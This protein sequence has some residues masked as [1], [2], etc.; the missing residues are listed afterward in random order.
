MTLGV[1]LIGQHPILFLISKATYA[2]AS[3]FKR[4]YENYSQGYYNK[5]VSIAESEIQNCVASS[6][7]S[8]IQAASYFKLGDF[9][10][11]HDILAEL[12]KIYDSEPDYLSLYAAASRRLGHL[13][14]SS[15]LFKLALSIEPNSLPIKNNYANLLIDLGQFEEAKQLLDEV[16]TAVPSYEDA[17]KNKNRLQFLESNQH[18]PLVTDNNEQSAGLVDLGDPLLLAFAD[19]EVKRSDK[20]YKFR[21]NSHPS[22]ASLPEPN[23]AES[24]EDFIKMAYQASSNGDHDFAFKLCSQSLQQIGPQAVIYDCV[25][26][27]FLN[28]KNFRESELFL[29]HAISLDGPSPKRLLNLCNFASM[30]G[31]FKLATHYLEAASSLDPS[32]PQLQPIS[33]SLA[34]KSSNPPFQFSHASTYPEVD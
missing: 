11:C 31:D 2:V 4:L 9:Q 3:L 5:V 21:R 16:L 1:S 6:D 18:V 13:E 25:S 22:L 12:E 32:H 23:S 17:I 10:K 27:L 24:A 8:K 30:R 19:E 33:R 15:Q 20:R 14:K 26:D 28:L 7:S 34:K 29:L